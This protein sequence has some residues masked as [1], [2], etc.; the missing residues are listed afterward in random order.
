M[1][2]RDIAILYLE[3]DILDFE[4]FSNHTPSE[5]SAL[6]QLKRELAELRK[7]Q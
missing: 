7:Q 3:M 2:K 4:R 1:S 5:E 6:R